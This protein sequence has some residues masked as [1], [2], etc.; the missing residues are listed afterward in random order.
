[1]RRAIVPLIAL[2]LLAAGSAVHAT[3]PDEGPTKIPTTRPNRL[4]GTP[5]FAGSSETTISG[6]VTDEEGSPLLD[7]AV[8]LYI[9]GLLAEEEL[10]S[11]DGSFEISMLID[12]GQDVT[13][14]IWFVP[15]TNDLVMENI[16]L[17]ESTAAVENAL[18]SDCVQRVRLDPLTDVFVKLTDLE[19]RS[20]RIRR[21]GCAG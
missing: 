11:T 16:I 4:T 18:Y 20:E 6:I 12:Y 19:T 17:K 21:S 14:D 13:I 10:T 1:M 9:G 8:K 15:S 2:A 3:G 5:G 7:V